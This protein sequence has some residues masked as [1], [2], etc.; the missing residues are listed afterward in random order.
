MDIVIDWKIIETETDFFDM[1]LPQVD[2]PEWHG[3]SL[4]ALGDSIVTGDING[5]EPP[6]IIR[7]I[8]VGLAP[9]GLLDFQSAVL[10]LFEEAKKAG[11]GI[12]VIH[13]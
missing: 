10:A 13:E 12:D 9:K 1:F 7:N 5:V 2:A 4:N 3:R 8:N 6:Y 11:R